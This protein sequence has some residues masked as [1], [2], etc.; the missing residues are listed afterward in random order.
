MTIKKINTHF[1]DFNSKLK[2]LS[3]LNIEFYDQDINTSILRFSLRQCEIAVNLAVKKMNAYIMLV[4]EDGSKVR[5]YLVVYDGKNGIVSYTIPKEFLQH[6]GR[7]TGQVYLY[8]QDNILVTRTFSFIIKD[9]LVNSFSAQTKLEYIKTYDDLET[10]IKNRVVEIEKAIANGSDYVAEI[11]K[12]SD[13]SHAK[14]QVVA[15]NAS[16]AVDKSV[17]DA[18]VAVEEKSNT[19]IKKVKETADS[20]LEK[21]AEYGQVPKITADNGA[22]RFD[23]DA[24]KDFFIETLTWGNG[25][26]TFYLSAGAKNNPTGS[27]SWLRGSVSI[28]GKNIDVTAFDKNGIMYTVPCVNGVYGTWNKFVQEMETTNWQKYEMMPANGIRPRLLNGTDLL[29]L[30]S[31]FYEVTQC[32][33]SPFSET[34]SSWKELD[35]IES[36]LGRKIL[37]LTISGNGRTFIRTVHTN[38]VG[39]R[40]WWEIPDKVELQNAVKE[41]KPATLW[42]GSANGVSTTTYTLTQEINRSKKIRITYDF[43]GGKGKVQIVDLNS[44]TTLA[45]RDL[46]L[47]NIDAKGGSLYELQ[48]DFTSLSNFKIVIDSVFDLNGSGSIN[49]KSFTIRKI[50]EVD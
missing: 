46:N 34:E 19:V 17:A 24:T 3:N 13:K 49:R 16:I 30:K 5:D 32:K 47:T 37:R 27:L 43:P 29:T 31:G 14:I 50:E 7:V 23:L 18:K 38:G 28:Y 25:F 15:N 36:D 6:T 8:H 21:I 42:Q 9:S 41:S 33:N 11:E 40:D 26:F 44:T 1:L 12:V 35:V 2:P 10:V 4:A 45:I 20:A 39:G 22:P 48:L